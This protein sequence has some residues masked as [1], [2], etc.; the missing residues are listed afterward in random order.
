MS[1]SA[2]SRKEEWSDGTSA[3]PRATK[4]AERGW[5]EE[6]ERKG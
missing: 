2:S 6:E 4:L 5:G 1:F 3:I